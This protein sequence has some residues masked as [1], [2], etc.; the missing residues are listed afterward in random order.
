M[1]RKITILIY[2]CSASPAECFRGLKMT[3]LIIASLTCIAVLFGL[4]VLL[5]KK[6]VFFGALMLVLYGTFF[7][8]FKI[9]EHNFQLTHIPY[10]IPVDK[11]SYVRE[12]SWGFGP[13]GNETGLIEY[14]LP[15]YTT[16]EIVKNGLYYFT[17]LPQIARNAGDSSNGYY[18]HWQ[19]T[20]MPI[21]DAWQGASMDG[22][23]LNKTT[24]PSIESFLDRYGFSIP[25]DA[26]VVARIDNAISTPGSYFA[27][28]RTGI[29]IVMP[30]YRKAVFAYAG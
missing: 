1:C 25:L 3:Y 9:Y 4:I 26:K 14:E 5:I 21:T 16:Q 8:T 30:K 12:E 6:P 29:L 18:E 23:P 20:P 27:Y 24:I 10:G 17:S 15:E 7:G 11:I 13:G 2:Q 22:E 19:E 28:G